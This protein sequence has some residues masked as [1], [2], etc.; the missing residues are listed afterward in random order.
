VLHWAS[1][2]GHHGLLK[3]FIEAKADLNALD[4]KMESPACLAAGSGHLGALRALLAAGASPDAPEVDVSRP[5][6][7]EFGASADELLGPAPSPRV[8]KSPGKSQGLVR[9]SFTAAS[10]VQPLLAPTPPLI[11]ALQRD[12]V[13]SIVDELLKARANVAAVDL[14]N[15]TALHVACQARNVAAVRL[16]LDRKA[17]VNA[18]NMELRTSL[19][20]A[21]A[22][23]ES[24][25]I[26]QLLDYK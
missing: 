18:Q 1:E 25:I 12:A 16:L 10:E 17:D 23:G 3:L 13:H 6:T 26:K 15:N 11:R 4:A 8:P 19:H 20:Y 21:A 7:A 5:G 2:S 24:R 22:I 14:R 9:R